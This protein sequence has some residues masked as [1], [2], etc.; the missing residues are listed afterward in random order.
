MRILLIEDEKISRVTLSDTL[1]KEG[2]EVES[3]AT[4]TEGLELFAKQPFDVVIT[5]LRL[6]SMDG[7]EVLKQVKQKDE[8]ATIILVT[9]YGTVETA[10]QALKLGAFDYITKPFSPDHLLNI[11]R[12]VERMK[13]I[14]D[15]N[16]KLKKQLE[17]LEQQTLVGHAP[18]M[19]RLKEIIRHVA[20][21]DS[22][23]LITGESGTG[24]EL[25]ARALHQNSWRHKEPFL[26]VNC[27]AIPESLLESE[28]F[29]YEKG[30][31]TGATRRHLGYFERANHGTL[32]I[33]DIDDLPVKMQVKLLRVLQEQEFIR[34]GGWE[35]V[36]IDVRVI[37]A[38]KVD[39][40]KRIAKGLFREDLFYRLNIIPIELPPL[41]ERKED[42]PELIEYFLKK[43]N[44]AEKL[45]LFTPELM[46]HLM[47]YDWPG[48][49]RELENFV[50]R[51]IAFSEMTSFDPY[52]LLP[53][54]MALEKSV[55]DAQT[56]KMEY[57]S[58]NQFMAAK[59]EEIINWALQKA[60]NNITKAAQL[61]KIPRTTL[62][63]KLIKI[64]ERKVLSAQG[65]IN[66]G[67]V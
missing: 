37:A 64:Q 54:K 44:A 14:L 6:P 40:K 4:G 23:V 9:A 24:K 36:K 8:H 56:F 41:R 7:I 31:F 66:Q 42:I 22:T 1:E 11:L 61:L 59:E 57:S 10:A 33:D 21:H 60:H 46:S 18:A 39:L 67:S 45:H 50:Q 30:A 48:N 19:R 28:L 38:T 32:F 52:E 15:E 27:A 12:N 34:I 25:V 17:I 35:A 29:G 55:H 43:Q 65:K 16:Q 58:F 47:A 5:D 49:V 20:R 13:R 2:H 62:R 3:A 63:S 53:G 51:F 26:A